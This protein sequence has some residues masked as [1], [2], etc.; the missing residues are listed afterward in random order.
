MIVEEKN[1]KLKKIIIVTCCVIIASMGIAP[2]WGIGKTVFEQLNKH[3][4]KAQWNAWVQ[5][6]KKINSKE[7]MNNT[8]AAFRREL[9]TIGENNY[10]L[11]QK[12]YDTFADILKRYNVSTDYLQQLYVN[13]YKNATYAQRMD[14]VVI[15]QMFKERLA[16]LMP[17]LN[18]VIYEGRTFRS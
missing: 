13:V 3:V 16:S 15:D 2:A 4:F 12:T 8:P 6:R 14:K 7:V 5:S 18:S 10:K 11:N 9:K 17:E 1:M